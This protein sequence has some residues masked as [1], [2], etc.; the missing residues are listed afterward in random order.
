MS[1]SLYPRRDNDDRMLLLT[2][3]KLP[4]LCSERLG[5]NLRS[6]SPTYLSSAVQGQQAPGKLKETVASNFVSFTKLFKILFQNRRVIRLRT[7]FCAA[8]NEIVFVQIPGFKTWFV[9][10]FISTVNKY[11]F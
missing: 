5:I 7:L 1:L 9:Q 8:G 3:D 2:P 6:L 11:T 10:A 4:P